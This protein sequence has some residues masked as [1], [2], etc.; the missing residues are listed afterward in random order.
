MITTQQAARVLQM[1]RKGIAP[2]AIASET[3][4]SLASVTNLLRASV[5]PPKRRPVRRRAR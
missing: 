1:A 3:G 4:L 5:Q 2:D